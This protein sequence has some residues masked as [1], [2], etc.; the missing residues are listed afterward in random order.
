MSLN[1]RCLA[2]YYNLINFNY[3]KCFYPKYIQICTYFIFFFLF[4][5]MNHVIVLRKLCNFLK[6]NKIVLISMRIKML[7][8]L[9]YI[10]IM[11]IEMEHALQVRNVKRKMEE[12][13]VTVPVVLVSV[14]FSLRRHVA[15]KSI[16]IQLI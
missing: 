14:A 2:F 6:I 12:Q 5:R 15:K 3:S 13:R 9:I 11:E 1:S 16:K 8:N 7:C 4:C 10:G